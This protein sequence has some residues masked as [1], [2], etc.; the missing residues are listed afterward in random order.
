MTVQD[1][2]D[3]A[4]D[5][6]KLDCML[7]EERNPP[8]TPSAA[9]KWQSPQEQR[10][11]KIHSNLPPNLCSLPLIEKRQISNVMLLKFPPV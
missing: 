4:G 5:C 11:I 9:I 10:F 8:S 2:G 7:C 1:M 6:E 3:L